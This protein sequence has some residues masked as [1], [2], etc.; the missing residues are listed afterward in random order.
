MI[1]AV[2]HGLWHPIAAEGITHIG[3]PSCQWSTAAV[4]FLYHIYCMDK[5]CRQLLTKH[6]EQDRLEKFDDLT[7]NL[8]SKIERLT[9]ENA[10]LRAH[11]EAMLEAESANTATDQ[12]G[13]PATV[14]PCT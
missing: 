12:V 10:G 11:H 6:S 1:A 8:K 7:H 14:M 13:R 5:D 3:R 4:A 9:L 2:V